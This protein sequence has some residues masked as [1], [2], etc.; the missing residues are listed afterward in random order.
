[1]TRQLKRLQERQKHKLNNRILYQIKSFPS[2]QL[3]RQNKIRLNNSN[4]KE[5]KGSY[6]QTVYNVPEK[7]FIESYTYRSLNG[8]KIKKN[9][10]GYNDNRLSVKV[11]N[12]NRRKR[13]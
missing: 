2:R 9:R 3:G 1:M 4:R 5:T 11:I 6:N 10:Y 13:R 7:Y 8:K 12:H